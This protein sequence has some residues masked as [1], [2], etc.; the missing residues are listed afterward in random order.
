MKLGTISRIDKGD[1][2]KSGEPIP[3]WVDAL[4]DPL[5]QFI[6]QVG[7]ALQNRLTF[8]DN[9]LTKIVTQKITHQTTIAINPR[10]T[11]QSTLRV[12]GVFLLYAG[13]QQVDAFGWKARTDGNIDVT[14]DFKTPGTYEC[15]ILILLG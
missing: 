8:E 7:L 2:S 3:K 4:L 13:G 5:N 15:K 14:I 12:Q 9:F 1:L 6:E 10:Q 11:A